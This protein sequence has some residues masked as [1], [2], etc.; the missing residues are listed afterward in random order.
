VEAAAMSV[1]VFGYGSLV[2]VASLAA[3]L[4]RPVEL[5]GLARLHGWRRSWG[6]ARDNEACEKTFEL[7]DGRRPA[8]CLGLD[9]CP[10]SDAPPPNGALFAVTE[11]EL[12][13]LDVREIRYE[14]AD[15]TA[16]IE[17]GPDFDRIITYRARPEHRAPFP[18]T[19]SVLIATYLKAVEGAFDALGPDQLD[20]FRETTGSPPVEV[21]NARLVADRI[22]AGNPRDW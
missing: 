9:V 13:R 20:L 19:D 22:P 21:V 5:A 8:F 15:V 18:R 1:A 11:P 10:D 2:N 7:A 6:L 12:D 17:A 3:T 14:R 16:A 4:G